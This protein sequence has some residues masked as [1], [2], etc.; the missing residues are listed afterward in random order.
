M[1]FR[2]FLKIQPA[3]MEDYW[4]YLSKAKFIFVENEPQNFLIE[5]GLNF[6][7]AK[8]KNFDF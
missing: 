8:V 6:L 5:P 3:I 2:A 7:V 4:A 1:I